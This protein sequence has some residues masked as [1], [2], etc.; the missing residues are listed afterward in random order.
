MHQISSLT[1]VNSIRKFERICTQVWGLLY[2]DEVA[3]GNTLC[4]L[5]FHGTHPS[6]LIKQG[7]TW[8]RSKGHD[9]GRTCSLIP[10]QY[11]NSTT[12]NFLKLFHTLQ[13]H[14]VWFAFCLTLLGPKACV[15]LKPYTSSTMRTSSSLI[16]VS[17]SLLDT[18]N[19]TSSADVSQQGTC[20]NELL[21]IFLLHQAPPPPQEPP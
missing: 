9:R 4:S 15:Y 14:F 19:C 5:Q 21:T 11:N 3:E 12:K 20:L 17:R 6:S 7:N 8:Q 13:C 18:I 1:W 16:S 2:S 10:L